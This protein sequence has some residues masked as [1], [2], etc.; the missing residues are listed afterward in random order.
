MAT[1]KKTPPK[2]EEP[3]IAEDLKDES[4]ENPLDKIA[5][6]IT[7]AKEE[8]AKRIRYS[9]EQKATILKWIED[10]DS[11]HGRGGAS[12]VA[13]K[14][15]ISP[16]SLSS[17][18]NDGGEPK[19][20]KPRTPKESTKTTEKPE[21]ALLKVLMGRGFDV[22]ASANILDPIAK[23]EINVEKP[24]DKILEFVPFYNSN[25]KFEIGLDQLLTLLKLPLRK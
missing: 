3:F 15:G 6:E 10:Y 11:T 19:T 9:E 13:T 18:K 21:I 16:I 22:S 1:K 2:T 24:L 25:G 23:I 20:R 5:A 4:T 12:Q 14:L 7:K 17:W 8:G